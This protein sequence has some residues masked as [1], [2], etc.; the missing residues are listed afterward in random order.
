MRE[1]FYE[2]AGGAEGMHRLAAAFYRRMF[3]D[4]LMVPLFA[5]LKADHVGR[6]A[7]WLGELFGGPAEHT[8]Q[9]GGIYTV[10][11]VHAPL[12]ISDAQRDRWIVY[13]L[14]ACDEVNMPEEVMA[15]FKPHIHFGALAAQRHSRR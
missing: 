12:K 4:P 8:E 2:L 1:T 14:A 11:D 9:R 6:M 5:N 7:L 3:D 10:I 15:F 13:M